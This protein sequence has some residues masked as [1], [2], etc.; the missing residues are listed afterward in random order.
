MLAEQP[1]VCADRLPAAKETPGVDA[2][3]P[4]IK[5]LKGKL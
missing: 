2:A 1:D 5:A 3:S 4:E